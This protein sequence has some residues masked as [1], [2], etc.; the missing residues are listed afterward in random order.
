MGIVGKL[1]E[2]GSEFDW[3]SPLAAWVQDAMHGGGYTFIVEDSAGR[4]CAAVVRELRRAGISS[5]GAM[6]VDGRLLLTVEKRDAAAATDVLTDLGCTLANPAPRA[7]RRGARRG[8]GRGAGRPAGRR[9]ADDP[10]AVFD[11]FSGGDGHVGR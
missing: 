9:L 7:A 5:W 10:F 3:I 8:A 4:V 11:I 6:V 1:L 2:A